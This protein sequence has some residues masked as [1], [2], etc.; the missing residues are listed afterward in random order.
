MYSVVSSGL[1]IHSTFIPA[2]MLSAT[3]CGSVR[4]SLMLESLHS[5]PEVHPG[6]TVE[7]DHSREGGGGQS[8]RVVEVDP[9]RTVEVDHSREGGGG[10][11]GRVVEV[12]PGR[13]GLDG[14]D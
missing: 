10:Q 6:R 12:D 1:M 5:S 7:V 4:G 2:V 11:S 8:G 14:S 13:A 3:S 9:G